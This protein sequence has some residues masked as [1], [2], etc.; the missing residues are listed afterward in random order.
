[1]F[2]VEADESDST[3]L[4]LPLMGA[5]LTNVDI[6]HLDNFQTFD[7]IR[8]SFKEF[9]S[10]V[11]GPHVLCV[12][13]PYC[14]E[15]A[16]QFGSITYSASLGDSKTESPVNADFVASEITFNNG[17]AQFKVSQN[18]ATQTVPLGIVNIQLR[19]IHNVRNALGA[20]V[21]AINLGASF[22]QAATALAKF[23]GV[24][25][26]FDN[27]GTHRGITY[28]DDYAHL[29]NEISA[30]LAGARDKS[31]SWSRV[32]AV[33]Q[34]NRF[35]RMSVISHLYAN[36]F[37]DA[38]LVVV[39]DIYAS[40][41]A[42]IAGVTGELV[43]NAIRSAHPNLK[44]I[45]QPKRSDLIEFLDGELKS[46]DLC[47]SMGCGDIAMLPSELISRKLTSQ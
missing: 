28:V 5:I 23:G 35:N 3:H 43:V 38:D 22:T 4:R 13:D 37:S 30:V 26:R 21:M 9:I 44:V 41:T 1:M 2:V 6:D 31:D 7:A 27:H 8:E 29:P 19:G 47:I 39:T 42:A 34:P 45:Y 33:F 14:A 46:G 25:R 12:D 10:K 11:N 36:S 18:T 20:L 40:G 24:A 16:Q 17:A 15:I 32:V